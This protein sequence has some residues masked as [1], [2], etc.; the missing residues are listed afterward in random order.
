MNRR[1]FLNK[2]KAAAIGSFIPINY[3]S[4]YEQ[5]SSESTNPNTIGSNRIKP[6]KITDRLNQGPFTTYGPKATAPE[7]YLVMVTAPSKRQITNFGMGMVTYLCDEVGPPKVP[8]SDLYAALEGLVKWPLGTKLYLRVD[9][10]DIQK[11]PGKLEFPEHWKISFDLARK[12]NKRIGLRVQLMSPVIKG[13]SIPDFL[14]DKIPFVKLGKTDE[15]GIKGKIHYAPRYDN[16]NFLKAFEELDML[17]S[18]EYNGNSLVEYVDTCMYGFWGEG[19]TWPFPGNPFP[20]KKI[21]ERTF[22]NMFAIQDKNWSKTP[23]VTNTQPDFSN[24]GNQ[25]LLEKTIETNNWLRTD[26]IFIETEQIE[27]LSNRPPWIGATIENGF[28]DGVS[29]KMQFIDGLPKTEMLISHIKDVSPNYCSLWNWHNLGVENLQRYYDKFPE[30]LDDLSSSIGYR[31][32]PSWIWLYEK[33]GYPYLIIGL[34]N[35]GTSGVPGALRIY[36]SDKESTFKV[37]GSIDPGHPLP[38]KVRQ[39][40]IKLPPGKDWQGLNLMAE[41]EVKGMRYPVEWACSKT[42]LNSDGSINLHQNIH[43]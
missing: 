35:D 33:E 13:H 18:E 40:E 27:A 2:G 6:P 9:W 22:L 20:S 11:R 7:N 25:A 30:G 36:V 8:Y 37:G 21:A 10:R 29:E 19:H 14:V 26:T 1:S 32:R 43:S 38:G 31:V 39:A 34:V 16:D 5:T 24:V 3:T 4:T 23:L 41:I 28:S 12:Y 42:L 17:L 15:I